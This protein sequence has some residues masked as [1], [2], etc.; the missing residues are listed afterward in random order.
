[1]PEGRAG[2]DEGDVRLA[3]WSPAETA[4][5]LEEESERARKRA[6]HEKKAR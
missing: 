6:Q 4:E 5:H 1:V 3:A 2:D